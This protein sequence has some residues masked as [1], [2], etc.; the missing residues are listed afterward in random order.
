MTQRKEPTFIVGTS[1]GKTFLSGLGFGTK[2]GHA[3]VLSSA[4]ESF[5]KVERELN[6]AITLVNDEI[7]EEARIAREAEQRRAAAVESGQKLD[8]ILQRVK[9]FTE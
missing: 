1:A 9:A 4:L 7:A 3:E 6:E 5:S 2:K 8:R